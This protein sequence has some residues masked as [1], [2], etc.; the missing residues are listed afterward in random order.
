M[1]E[2]APSTFKNSAGEGEPF[3]KRLFAPGGFEWAFRMR[4]GD[5]A[6]FFAPQDGSGELLRVRGE[7]LDAHLGRYLVS[8]PAG[9]R[10]ADGIWD[11]AVGWGAVVEPVD[12]ARDLES[13]SRLLEADLLMMDQATKE[14]AGGAVCFPSSWDPA[15]AVGKTLNEVHGVVPRLNPQIGEMINRFIEK[16][17]PGD[18]FCR[19]NWSFTRTDDLDYHP[20]VGRGRLDE[21]LTLDELFLRIEH[22]LFTG[23]PGGVLMGIRIETCPLKELAADADVW[24]LVAEKIRTM[25]EDVAKY[26]SMDAAIPRMLEV[27]SDFQATE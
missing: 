23:I 4:K 25:P 12:G 8:T 5:A 13:L 3:W 16:V 14:V 10:L 19:E 18:S 20:A 7:S 27:M 24:R 11:L 6:A 9:D 26:K 15:H 21:S 22:Q 2:P 17:S 1:S